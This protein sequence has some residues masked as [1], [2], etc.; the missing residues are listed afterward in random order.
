MGIV[1][2][3][4]DAPFDASSFAAD[5]QSAI[6]RSEGLAEG[7]VGDA[8]GVATDIISVSER[9]NLVL[10]Q[11]RGGAGLWGGVPGGRTRAVVLMP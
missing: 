6:E 1:D 11:V 7:G 4:G 9:N 3:T 8:A 2:G 10:P 5:L